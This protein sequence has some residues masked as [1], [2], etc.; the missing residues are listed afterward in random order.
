MAE[1][2]GLPSVPDREEMEILAAPWQP[3]RA[4]AARLIWHGYLSSRGRL[5]PPDPVAGHGPDRDA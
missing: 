3:V 2:L 5:E 4:V 1:V